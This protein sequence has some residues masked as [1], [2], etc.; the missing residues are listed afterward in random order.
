MTKK[1]ELSIKDVENNCFTAKLGVLMGAVFEQV[2]NREGKG[3]K[4]SV[5]KFTEEELFFRNMYEL[6][7]ALFDCLKVIDTA[8]DFISMYNKKYYMRKKCI[9]FD[10]FALYHFDVFCHKV[11]TIKDLYFKIINIVYELN[12]NK[13]NISWKSI[14]NQRLKIN[15]LD[16]FIC[17][18]RFFNLCSDI[19]KKRHKSSHEGY[20]NSSALSDIS[21]YLMVSD[22]QE[23]VPQ[24]TPSNPIY[25]KDSYIYRLQIKKAKKEFVNQLRGKRNAI[26]IITRYFLCSL[27]LQLEKLRIN[28]IPDIKAVPI[29]DSHFCKCSECTS[30]I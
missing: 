13:N 6:H 20:I 10:K 11:S 21:L 28:K 24:F 17:L 1:Y 14:D 22:L 8:I 2:G 25:V 26:F 4:F 9:P 12:L 23:K 27:E 30:T 5:D 19:E 18:E 29:G 16:V 15:N 3:S 7:M